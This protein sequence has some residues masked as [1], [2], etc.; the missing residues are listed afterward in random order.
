MTTL[1]DCEL[2]V[3]VG[4]GTTLTNYLKNM[5]PEKAVISINKRADFDELHALV[6]QFKQ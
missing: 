5:Y 1:S 3:E 2:L 6:N 4:P